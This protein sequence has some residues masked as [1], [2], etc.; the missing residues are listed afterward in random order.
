MVFAKYM[1][2]PKYRI[3]IIAAGLTILF[4]LLG[5]GFWFVHKYFKTKKTQQAT[6]EL[7]QIINVQHSGSIDFKDM[8]DLITDIADKYKNTKLYPFFIAYKSEFE[9]QQNN[10]KEAIELLDKMSDLMNS[11][12]PLYYIY[13]IKKA[14]IKLDSSIDDFHK[15][16]YNELTVLSN[17]MNNPLQ[18]MA[19]YNLGVYELS[20]SN[21]DEAKKLFEVIILRDRKSSHWY[22]VAQ[23]KLK[24]L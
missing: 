4:M 16:G 9:L 8:S 2:N 22:S 19:T 15:Q 17:D 11:K 1:E 14:L 3:Y 12:E 13:S 23:D 5:A 7:E 18:D 10:E 6:G 21:K 24:F 20:K